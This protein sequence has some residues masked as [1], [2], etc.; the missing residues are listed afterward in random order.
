[1]A[2]D[3]AS[4]HDERADRREAGP[5]TVI[6]VLEVFSRAD[7]AAQLVD[8]AL[9][10]PVAGAKSDKFALHLDG[11]VLGRNSRAT[12]VQVCYQDRLIR[13]LP[14][15]YP[16]RGLAK[17][18]PEFADEN[19]CGFNELVGVVGFSREF[20]LNL[21][22]VLEDGSSI[23]FRTIRARHEPI[24]PA[25]DPKL[26]PIMLTS[27]P[28]TG[29]T[30][31]MRMLAVHPNIV[32]YRH[33]PYERNNAEYWAHMLKVLIEPANTVESSTR[34]LHTDFWWVGSSPFY[35]RHANEDEEL[36]RWFGRTYG[37]RL[38]AFC[39]QSI[40]DLYLKV[41]GKQ[42]QPAPVYFAEKH[43]PGQLPTLLWEL[44][45]RAKEIFLT[46][47]PR[48]MVCSVFNFWPEEHGDRGR[49]QDDRE[50]IRWL[51]GSALELHRD[52]EQRSRTGHLLRYEDS[53]LEPAKTLKAL[54][55][56]LEVDSSPRTIEKMLRAAG[57]GTPQNFP[58]HQTAGTPEASV[59][60]WRRDLD[61]SLRDVCEE[62]FAPVLSSFGYSD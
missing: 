47:D 18:H 40:D 16:R 33:F 17:S 25:F 44:Y 51:G 1:V 7:T 34:E 49:A 59:G 56:Y 37:E 58:E 23:P 39:Q 29:T 60:R 55:G 43:R 30:R 45:P 53:V 27:L 9:D 52:W 48:D 24:R 6:E 21:R 36:G 38:A 10:H 41:A 54:L 61:P 20:S 2:V 22:A 46:R 32:V 42:G 57:A 28:R 4:R 62:A 15:D 35:D 19:T 3:Q 13:T 5:S 12:G 50:F 31:L 26:R 8:F 14:L 11:W